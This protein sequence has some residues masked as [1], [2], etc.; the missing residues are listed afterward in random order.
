[1]EN[2]QNFVE[3]Q[4]EKKSR[5]LIFRRTTLG[6]AS[7]QSR[8]STWPSGLLRTSLVPRLGRLRN[9]R[10]LGNEWIKMDREGINPITTGIERI[11]MDRKVTKHIQTAMYREDYCTRTNQHLFTVPPEAPRRRGRLRRARNDKKQGLELFVLLRRGLLALLRHAP[12][13]P[14]S[15]DTRATSSRLRRGGSRR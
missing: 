7:H 4:L 10:C 2:L 8:A 6:P 1:M 13:N 15:P 3:P 5:R 12:R 11:K 9:I 14:K